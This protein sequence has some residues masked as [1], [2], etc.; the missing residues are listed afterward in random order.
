M[1]KKQKQKA[2]KILKSSEK[3][4]GQDLYK[5]WEFQKNKIKIKGC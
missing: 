3:K 5:N 2:L 1:L 4:T